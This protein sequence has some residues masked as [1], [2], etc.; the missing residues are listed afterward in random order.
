[1]EKA[2]GFKLG[3]RI[4]KV[5]GCFVNRRNR[6]R[7]IYYNN[8][9][10]GTVASSSCASR[11]IS[12]LCRLGKSSLRLILG[13]GGGNNKGGLCFGKRNSGYIR[14]GQE[15]QLEQVKEVVS[16]P[17]GHLAVYVG[18]KN[19]DACRVFVPVIYFNHPLF[20]EL[21]RESEQIYGFNHQG[22]I[23]IP[24]QKSK[25]ENVK[26]RIAAAASG[27]SGS[28]MCRGRRSWR[29][30]LAASGGGSDNLDH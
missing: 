5:F 4:V 24:C 15:E 25:F 28:S 23:Q 22:G 27:G 7:G 20:S 1:M 12:K 6:T 17:K 13:F 3:R 14:V 9:R 29:Q 18:E 19:G 30:L 2:R 21:L 16:V 8:Q 26:M 10:L 11:A